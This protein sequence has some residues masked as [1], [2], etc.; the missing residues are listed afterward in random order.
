MTTHQTCVTR[1]PTPNEVLFLSSA[2]LLPAMGVAHDG[3]I[4]FIVV[5]IYYFAKYKMLVEIF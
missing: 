5:E 2:T 4:F 1:R 3:G